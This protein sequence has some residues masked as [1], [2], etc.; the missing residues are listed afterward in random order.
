MTFDNPPNPPVYWCRVTKM[1]EEEHDRMCLAYRK[2]VQG[3][4]TPLP[5]CTIFKLENPVL[6]FEA[7][8]KSGHLFHP[9]RRAVVC[10]NC[11]ASYPL[12]DLLGGELNEE[13]CPKCKMT[14]W[15][16]WKGKPHQKVPFDP[17]DSK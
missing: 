9:G 12:K 17:R 4:P 14:C 3:L 13:D 2:K 10:Q 15:E 5:Y 8:G 11:E 6:M 16:F 7:D 1:T